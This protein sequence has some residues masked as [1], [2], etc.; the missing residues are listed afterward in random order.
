VRN[1]TGAVLVFRDD[2]GKRWVQP[3]EDFDVAGAQHEP[4]VRALI[5]GGTPA[6]DDPAPA[7]EA[8]ATP[9]SRPK[10]ARRVV[11]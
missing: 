3:G 11:P 5:E 6:A 8:A 1:T 2:S 10:K 7:G 4:M 9:T